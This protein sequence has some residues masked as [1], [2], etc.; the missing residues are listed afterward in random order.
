[1]FQKFINWFSRT[2]QQ[3]VERFIISKNPQSPADV[4]HWLRQ[5]DLM[6]MSSRFF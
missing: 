2:P 5:Y 4:D 3:E 6:I 1:M